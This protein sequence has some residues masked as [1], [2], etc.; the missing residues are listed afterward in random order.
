MRGQLRR[1]TKVA[2]GVDTEPKEPDPWRVLRARL[3]GF[4][5]LTLGS[6]RCSRDCKKADPAIKLSVTADGNL[7]TAARTLDVTLDLPE[8][9]YSRSFPLGAT[10]EDGSTSLVVELDSPLSS[11]SSVKITA[12]ALP[13]PPGEPLARIEGSFA[14]S[15]DACNELAL[16]LGPV[17][18][19]GGV[20]AGPADDARP[21]D[22]N[23]GLDAEVVDRGVLDALVNMDSRPQ[24]D[25]DP[26]PLDADV[27]DAPP[28][29]AGVDTGVPDV[30]TPDAGF[31]GSFPFRPSNFDPTLVPPPAV[32]ILLDCDASFDSTTNQFSNWCGAEPEVFLQAQSDGSEISVISAG[33]LEIRTGSTLR[34]QGRRPVVLAIA[35]TVTIAGTI[36]LGAQSGAPGAGG[37]V[38]CGAS[39]G[40]DG[41]DFGGGGGGGG[42]GG[43]AF[44]GM[45]G[46]ASPVGALGGIGGSPRGLQVLVP[47]LGGCGGGDGARNTASAG[48]GGG[49]LQ[50]TS[51]EVILIDGS[52]RAGGGGGKVGDRRQAG[53]GGGSGGGILLEGKVV[54]L[55]SQAELITTGG[56]GGEGGGD[57]SSNGSDGEDGISAVAHGGSTDDDGGDGGDGGGL[58]PPSDGAVGGSGRAGGG[59]GGGSV[60]RI[61]IRGVDACSLLGT[62]VPGTS[63]ACP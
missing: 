45:A 13:E 41:T 52:I 11:P 49:A 2:A 8:G 10:L 47:L 15:P 5:L 57:N 46:G 63:I 30:G 38:G 51:S 14:I 39:Q 33:A 56:G 21:R 19:D 29:D 3:V 59:G 37:S 34:L 16:A 60:G 18:I 26:P 24:T 53:G 32:S 31:Y 58:S 25:A 55:T 22:A 23:A 36:D 35:G 54:D 48:A 9:R 28:P 50:I 40:A 6:V 20:D 61:R 42:G 7:R 62:T 1:Q 12:L 4:A 17:G 43:N 27:P 44:A